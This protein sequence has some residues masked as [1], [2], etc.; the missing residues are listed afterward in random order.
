MNLNPT[1]HSSLNTPFHTASVCHRR[2][3][4]PLLDSIRPR[5]DP[6]PLPEEVHH[7]PQ[8]PQQRRQA[9]IR[10]KRPIISRRLNETRH[11]ITRAKTDKTPERT[12][13]DQNRTTP[14]RV[15]IQ[16]QRDPD[17]ITPIKTKDV[18]RK[19]RTNRKPMIPLRM[20][21]RLAIQHRTDD[22]H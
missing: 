10:P 9:P 8:T 2:P 11:T 7:N 3:P 19:R 18:S 22:T 20:L 13:H 1:H 16:Q 17:H 4:T 14:R 5:K 21:R 6:N 15:R 12:Y